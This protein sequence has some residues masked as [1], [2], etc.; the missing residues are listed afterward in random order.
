MWRWDQAEPFGANP[1]DEDPDA[2]SSTFDLPLRLPG[3]RYD[4]ESGLLYNF[5]RDYDPSLGRYGES[6]PIEL[7]GGLNTYAYGVASPLLFVDTDGLDVAC[8]SAFDTGPFDLPSVGESCYAMGMHRY[9]RHQ[10]RYQYVGPLVR[11]VG[12]CGC[13]DKTKTCI[14]A[15]VFKSWHRETPCGGGPWSP[16]KEFPSRELPPLN[17]VIDCKSRRWDPS[18]FTLGNSGSLPGK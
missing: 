2:N 6:D 10:D 1:A 14:Y 18:Q 4:A 3:Q 8:P 5:F 17:A 9:Y 12:S 16:W 7:R 15:L 11:E 13:G